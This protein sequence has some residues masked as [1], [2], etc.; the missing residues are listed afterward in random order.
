[1]SDNDRA[2]VEEAK[3]ILEGIRNH[4]K[5]ST[6]KLSKFEKQVDDLKKARFYLDRLIELES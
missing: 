1:M 5:T 4:Q 3:G 6:E 2:M